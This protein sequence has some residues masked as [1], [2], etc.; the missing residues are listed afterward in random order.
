MGAE[1]EKL[2]GKPVTL[3]WESDFSELVRKVYGRPYQFQQQEGCRGQETI[4]KFSVPAQPIGDHYQAVPMQQWL[5]ATPPPP[6]EPGKYDSARYT[7][8]LRWDREFY[9]EMEEVVNDL[10]QK[11]LIDPGE[12]ALHIWW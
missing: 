7:E 4:Y 10:H 9:P 5:E 3:I 2:T 8:E 1:P 11:G 12:Y 6:A